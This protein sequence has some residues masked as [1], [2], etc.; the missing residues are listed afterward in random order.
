[1]VEPVI[2][3]VAQLTPTRLTGLLQRKGILQAG[4]VSHIQV[5]AQTTSPVSVRHQLAIE[6]TLGAIGTPLHHKL[7]LRLS[8]PDFRHNSP[9]SSLFYHQLIPLMRAAWQGSWPFAECIDTIWSPTQKLDHLLLEDLSTTH[10]TVNDHLPPTPELYEQLID[11]FA[12]FHAFWWDHPLLGKEISSFMTES[13][14]EQLERDLKT[15]LEPLGAIYH[16]DLSEE[17]FSLVHQAMTLWPA[18]H[19][20]RLGQGR[21]FTLVHRDPHPGNI[22]YPHHSVKHSIK[23]VDWQSWRID[24]GTDDLAYLIAFHWP[25]QVRAEREGALLQRYHQRLVALGVKGYTWDDCTY[26]YRASI[27]RFIAVMGLHW[28]HPQNRTRMKLG[29]QAYLDWQCSQ[30]L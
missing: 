22:L 19:R 3:D 23:L 12:S 28:R 16:N 5:M 29:L 17:Q 8:N 20:K 13:T 25:A 2:T 7:F 24:P 18:L 4:D 9:E 1:M 6:Y 14:I 11:I 26:D 21:D 10:F 15:Q 30:L 27:L